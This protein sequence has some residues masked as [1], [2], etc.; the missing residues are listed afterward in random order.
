MAIPTPR[1]DVFAQRSRRLALSVVCAASIAA[2]TLAGPLTATVHAES[3]RCRVLH[4]FMDNTSSASWMW[5][6]ASVEY[7]NYCV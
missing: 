5:R 1:L 3:P 2:G 4:N 6:A 7:G